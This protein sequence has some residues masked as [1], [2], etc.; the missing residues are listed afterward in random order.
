MQ[1]LQRKINGEH[2]KINGEESSKV[3]PKGMQSLCVPV[4]V[5]VFDIF[6]ILHHIITSFRITSHHTSYRINDVRIEYGVDLRQM[7][8]KN[9][10]VLRHEVSFGEY[11]FISLA[12]KEGILFYKAWILFLYEA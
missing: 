1:N 10:N 7:L 2:Q 6:I 12:T 3:V 4:W 9:E 11:S 5:C 8:R